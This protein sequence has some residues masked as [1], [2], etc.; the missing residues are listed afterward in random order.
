MIYNAATLSMPSG[1]YVEISVPV[2]PT[3]GQG[4]F[5]KKKG[6]T[7]KMYGKE[8]NHVRGFFS[9]D[10]LVGTIEESKDNTLKVKYTHLQSRENRIYFVSASDEVFVISIISIPVHTHESIEQGGPAYGTYMADIDKKV[11]QTNP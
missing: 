10:E 5:P 9:E 7:I 11:E 3:E 4:S 8:Y 6:E 1:N 2:F